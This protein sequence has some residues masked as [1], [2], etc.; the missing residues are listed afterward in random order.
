M[1][2]PRA[3]GGKPTWPSTAGGPP[4][5]ASTPPPASGSASA[6]ATSRKLRR[7]RMSAPN[8]GHAVIAPGHSRA[9][10]RGARQPGL[11]R[12][13]KGDS[14][15]FTHLLARHTARTWRRAASPW[16]PLA[17]RYCAEDCWDLAA[18]R[19]PDGTRR[20]A[21]LPVTAIVGNLYAVNLHN[22]TIGS[23]QSPWLVE[24]V[25]TGPSD[26]APGREVTL[27]HTQAE[28]SSSPPS[29]TGEH[30]ARPTRAVCY[31]EPDAC[32]EGRSAS[33]RNDA[34]YAVLSSPRAQQ[35]LGIGR[36]SFDRS[37]RKCT[38]RQR[39]GD[40]YKFQQS[41]GHH[42]RGRAVDSAAGGC[43]AACGD[44]AIQNAPRGTMGG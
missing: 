10:G 29:R 43:H 36:A 27:C 32:L 6:I 21:G 17:R 39:A 1:A 23:S 18:M 25:R 33:R 26:R 34:H 38:P 20:Q 7:C 2:P 42:L 16:S 24:G 44:P 22:R 12:D 28:T 15:K 8:G 14:L 4:V 41:P 35:L 30:G 40:Q 37:S 11:E 13:S 31:P 3:G 5:A 9:R 19:Y